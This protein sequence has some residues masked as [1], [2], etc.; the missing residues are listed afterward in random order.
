MGKT[1]K[2]DA[3]DANGLLHN[4]TLPEN[5]IPPGGSC[6]IAAI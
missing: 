5:W 6:A 1:N 2:T 3:L 4:G